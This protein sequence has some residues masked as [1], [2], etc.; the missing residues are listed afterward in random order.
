[1]KS[2]GGNTHTARIRLP[3]A[4]L[5]VLLWLSAARPASLTSAASMLP[6]AGDSS[7]PAALVGESELRAFLKES[8]YT[9]GALTG[10]HAEAQTYAS[11]GCWIVMEY[12]R[13]GYQ[14]DS[15]SA[16]RLRRAS[17]SASFS[18]HGSVCVNQ[19]H[20]EEGGVVDLV[21]GLELR[22]LVDGVEEAATSVAAFD[23]SLPDL[24][25]GNHMI[26]ALVE[27][28]SESGQHERRSGAHR[29]ALAS[30][31]AEIVILK[32]VEI[33]FPSDE[34]VFASGQ[35][36]VL[37]IG[38]SPTAL[39]HFC[40]PPLDSSPRCQDFDAPGR[41]IG[42]RIEM[43]GVTV[44]EF[45]MK[46]S[47]GDDGRRVYHVI[48]EEG[49]HAAFHAVLGF[50]IWQGVGCFVQGSGSSCL[51][52]HLNPQTAI[53]K[54]LSPTLA[55]MQVDVTDLPINFYELSV[56]LTGAASP[57]TP[58]LPRPKVGETSIVFFEVA[59][60][61]RNGLHCVPDATG[62][63]D[64]ELH[65]LEPAEGGDGRG[66]LAGQAGRRMFR[67]ACPQLPSPL[68]VQ[69]RDAGGGGGDAG[70]CSGHG[71]CVR[72]VCLCT[73]DWIGEDCQ[74]SLLAETEYLPSQDPATWPGRCEQGQWWLEG[75]QALLRYVA[76]THAASPD[77]CSKD[78][79]LVFAT[80]MHGL[81]AQLH[82]LTECLTTAL[83]LGKGMLVGGNRSREI[84]CHQSSLVGAHE[85]SRELYACYLEP[86]LECHVSPP[87]AGVQDLAHSGGDEDTDPW[88]WGAPVMPFTNLSRYTG[89]EFQEFPKQS[90]FWWRAQVGRLLV[91]P[92]PSL[93][94]VLQLVKAS[95]GFEGPV[96]GVHVRHGD[97]CMHASISRFRPKCV[98]W[99]AYLERIYDM[100]ARYGV[101]KVFL[102][103]D[104][105]EVAASA[106]RIS[107][108]DIM[109]LSLDRSIFDADWFLEF[110]SELGLVDSQLVTESALLDLLFLSE[111]SYFVGT[112]A[113]HL[114]RLAF[115]LMV[116]R[117]G[118]FPPYASVDYPWCFHM[119]HKDL[120][121][122]FGVVNC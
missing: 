75:E 63:H 116:A 103:T 9:P 48:R 69:G 89:A 95:L 23:V 83:L 79:S 104:D 10:K 93:L 71:E 15:T 45:D 12:P 122:G 50:G 54:P 26:T 110:R 7:T 53:R 5:P 4:I 76:R 82:Y 85:L 105:D 90:A 46:I 107:D 92:R 77:E 73:G 22:V 41:A 18:V 81:G 86:L 98:D 16:P 32:D 17:A 117:L 55:S 33:L 78:T 60:C 34:F 14:G 58:D 99:A 112:F 2:K 30:L 21:E 111:A 8:N 84:P 20:A 114:S 61:A 115:E 109:H 52:F 108:L 113:S 59:E 39:E 47:D 24:S 29:A 106:A 119:M 100:S 120:V 31:A 11:E 37:A 43:N 25:S 88:G 96:I 40:S 72:G 87:G 42:L 101:R 19:G 74:H 44:S 70:V 27:D 65:Q 49:T 91:R 121:P 66:V 6:E 57:H 118:Y 35:K 1:M 51:L 13:K 64:T 94:A 62:D 68:C 67:F 102:A 38:V 3:P 36:I 56:S 97:A 28:V 80:R